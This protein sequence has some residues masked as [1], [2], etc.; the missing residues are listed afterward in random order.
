MYLH[1][2]VYGMYL[3]E[4]FTRRYPG[5][6]W[7]N[8]RTTQTHLLKLNGGVPRMSLGSSFQRDL[9]YTAAWLLK[10]VVGYTL[11]RLLYQEESDQ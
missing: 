4:R 1:D 3:M 5:K 7:H 2:S 10:K 8:G 11:H 6:L 9:L